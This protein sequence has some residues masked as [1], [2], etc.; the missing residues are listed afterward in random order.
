M[1]DGQLQVYV[2]HEVKFP[3]NDDESV[4]IGVVQ[5]D[6]GHYECD[7]T[8]D[9]V[10]EDMGDVEEMRK[11]AAAIAAAADFVEGLEATPMSACSERGTRPAF[12]TPSSLCPPWCVAPAASHRWLLDD[13]G[14]FVCHDGPSWGPRHLRIHGGGDQRID[15]TI[16]VSISL[17][18]L[19]DNP[20]MTAS[21][22]REFAA[23]MLAAS[24][25]LNALDPVSACPEWCSQHS[26]D[27][28]GHV[29]HGAD[30][31][32]LVAVD[33]D[34]EVRCSLE[35]SDGYPDGVGGTTIFVGGTEFRMDEAKRLS[36]QLVAWVDVAEG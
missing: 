36:A 16:E 27:N 11:I 31:I 34:D 20:E 13:R 25:W 21:E 33:H 24:E 29:F 10:V 1:V 4:L 32:A 9:R 3:L 30:Q 28:E 22:A 23:G 19:E 2:D 8:L 5:F 26:V 15:G 14:P 12:S 18:L 6:D 7:V 17:D 35:R